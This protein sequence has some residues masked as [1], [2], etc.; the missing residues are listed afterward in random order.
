[1][2]DVDIEARLRSALRAD[3]ETLPFSIT[4]AELERRSAL[5]RRARDSR[6]LSLVAAGVAALAVGALVVLASGWVRTP[7]VGESSPAAVIPPSSHEP[8]FAPAP[9]AT[10]D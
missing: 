9:S 7:P 5:R 1:M 4:H 10:A 2:R 8:S 3:A 6:R